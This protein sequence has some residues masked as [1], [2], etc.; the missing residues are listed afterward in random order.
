MVNFNECLIGVAT[1]D[2]SGLPKEYFIAVESNLGISW[3]QPVFQVIGLRSLFSASLALEHFQYAIMQG[4]DMATLV[5]R[6]QSDYL[7]LL[8]KGQIN[9]AGVDQAELLAWAKTINLDQF[10]NN[11]QY[12]V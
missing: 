3:M 1:F 2:L 6:K 10:R 7:A 8:L 12:S 5:L 11:P 9:L 4:S